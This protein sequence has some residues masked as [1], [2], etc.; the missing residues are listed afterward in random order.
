MPSPFPGMDPFIESQMW[1][2]FHATFVPAM[3]EFLNPV[4]GP[5]YL[6]TVEKYVYLMTDEDEIRRLLGPDVHIATTD[7]DFDVIGSPSDTSLITTL[8]PTL[9]TLPSLLRLE[10]ASLAI[11]TSKG[12]EVVTVIELLSPWNKSRAEGQPEYL[13]K[14]LGYFHSSAHVVEIDLLRGG[15][16]LPC[17]ES[18]P[19]GDYFT[20]V[21]RSYRRPKLDVYAWSL[22]DPL[23]TIPIPLRKGETDL[24]LDL[25]QVF[26]SVYERGR[27]GMAIDYD[28]LLTPSVSDDDRTWIDQQIAAWRADR[29]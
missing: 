1:L 18:L 26:S 19:A 10:Q 4:L 24:P 29:P 3:R 27:Y 28:E 13:T 6:C 12:R 9:L 15:V 22:R 25:S 21:S 14:R 5:G 20:N 17:R 16:R 23:P 8:K 2:D 7:E 11:R